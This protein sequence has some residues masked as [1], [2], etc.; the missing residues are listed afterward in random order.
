LLWLEVVVVALEHQEL[1]AARVRVV[2]ENQP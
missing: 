2:I 1:A